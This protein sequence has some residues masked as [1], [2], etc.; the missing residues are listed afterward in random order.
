MPTDKYGIEVPVPT[1]VVP[2]L[3]VPYVCSEGVV[4]AP[5]EPSVV[6]PMAANVPPM[7]V[8]PVAAVTEKAFVP[9]VKSPVIVVAPVTASVLLN[10]ALPVLVKLPVLVRVDAV[11]GPRLLVFAVKVPP[12]TV[13]PPL[14]AARP[15][16]PSVP[17]RVAAPE[18]PSVP[19][20]RML[21]GTS[22]L[23]VES[24]DTPDAPYEATVVV[25][26]GVVTC[27]TE[28]RLTAFAAFMLVV[29]FPDAAV[30]SPHFVFTTPPG[31]AEII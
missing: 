25:P 16:T 19:P 9:T 27:H 31:P 13:A 4:V 7:L 8:F 23:P 22:R 17:L 2:I 26:A 15:L 6:V 18:T 11:V 21:C 30:A 14:R 20:T 24:T 10:V 5:D 28:A 3:T 1:T 29:K 12:E